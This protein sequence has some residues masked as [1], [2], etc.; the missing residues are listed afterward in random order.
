MIAVMIAMMPII[1]WKIPKFDKP[2]IFCLN[3]FI[4]IDTTKLPGKL[5]GDFVS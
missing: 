2:M 3:Y 5:R 4:T 1:V